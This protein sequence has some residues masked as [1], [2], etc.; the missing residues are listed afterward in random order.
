MMPL[1]FLTT[2]ALGF[3]TPL[4]AAGT[5]LSAAAPHA[6]LLRHAASSVGRRSIPAMSDYRPDPAWQRDSILLMCYCGLEN[7]VRASQTGI[8]AV[9]GI[10]LLQLN[11]ELACALLVAGCWLLAALPTGV[12]GDAR[13]DR[14]RVFLT[15]GLAAAPAMALRWL[16]FQGNFVATPA[17]ICTDAVATLGLMIA[18]RLAE[19]QGFV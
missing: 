10:D 12:L 13:Y 15:W 14:G 4:S 19:E 3:G 17:A 11:I 6:I 18:L 1:A 7:L 9:P 8:K 16:A 5:P 2:A